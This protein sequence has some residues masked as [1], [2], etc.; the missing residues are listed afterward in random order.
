MTNFWL[1]PFIAG[2]NKAS[3]GL[4]P[5]Q[6]PGPEPKRL[7]FLPQRKVPALNPIG[8]VYASFLTQSPDS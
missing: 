6:T 8:R 5:S 3:D 2:G 7:C 1:R 4:P